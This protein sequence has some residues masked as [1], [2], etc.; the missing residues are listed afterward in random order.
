MIL[1][2]IISGAP[3][4]PLQKVQGTPLHGYPGKGVTE[5]GVFRGQ[6]SGNY[7]RA[8]IHHEYDVPW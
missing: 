3:V 8:G 5:F 2:F 1:K 7:I 6:W 4:T